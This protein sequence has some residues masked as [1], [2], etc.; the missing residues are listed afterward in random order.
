MA[1][2]AM[3]SIT[4]SSLTIYAL[5]VTPS[6]RGFVTIVFICSFADKERKLIKL[7][8]DY[9]RS[10]LLTYVLSQ[11]LRL[12]SVINLVYFGLVAALRIFFYYSSSA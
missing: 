1:C 9:K 11:S 12:L 7:Y 2:V 5:Y 6:Q 8:A 4:L 3:L 10:R